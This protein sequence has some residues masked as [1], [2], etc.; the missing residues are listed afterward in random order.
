MKTKILIIIFII[1]NF[2][3][4]SFSN[5][6]NCNEF[7]KF[8]VNYMKCKAN[9]IKNKTISVGKNFV[10]DTK[11]YQKKE[12][13]KEKDKLNDIKEKVLEK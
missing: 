7:K 5:E 3:S 4:Y 6:V 8:S 10:E 11:E 13:S 1:L 2:Y 12:W 9:L